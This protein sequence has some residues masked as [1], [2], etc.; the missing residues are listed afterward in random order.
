MSVEKITQ[1]KKNI[2][3]QGYPKLSQ[4]C[5][6]TVNDSTGTLP[7]VALQACPWFPEDGKIVSELKR[8]QFNGLGLQ[9]ALRLLQLTII[10]GKYQDSESPAL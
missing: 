8:S 7:C 5:I 4:L 1:T 6:H 2:L 9:A 10:Y 3:F